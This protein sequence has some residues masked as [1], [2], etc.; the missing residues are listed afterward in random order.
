MNSPAAKQFLISKIV[1]EAELENVPL[2]DVEKKMLYFTEVHPSFPVYEVNAE[3]ERNYDGDK[4]EAKVAGLLKR[5]RDRDR[6]VSTAGEEHG[7]DALDELRK[8]DHYILVM[9][10]QAF[11]SAPSSK[12]RLRD[13]LI[14]IAVGIGIV[15]LL[16]LYAFWS[17]RH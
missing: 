5:A 4:Y 10:R 17:A 7:T 9:V 8:E 6:K 13:F 1:Q 14:Y 2:S 11:G 12:S 15:L 3:F 16:V